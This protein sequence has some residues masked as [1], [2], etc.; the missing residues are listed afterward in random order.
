MK[1]INR[2]LFLLLLSANLWAQPNLWEGSQTF[3][4][5]SLWNGANHWV[6][7]YLGNANGEGPDTNG[8]TRLHAKLSDFY[9]E[10]SEEPIVTQDTNSIWTIRFTDPPEQADPTN[11]IRKPILLESVKARTNDLCVYTVDGKTVLRVD[12][13]NQVWIRGEPVGL[14]TTNGFD[15]TP[16]LPN[17]DTGL[18]Y[19]AIAAWR[20]QDVRDIRLIIPIGQRLWSAENRASAK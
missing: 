20:N 9:V 16:Q 14:I 15:P 7:A 11:A 6:T 5:L 8:E 13:R 1:T 2:S 10:S 3:S 19:G 4:E 17:F 12:Y 18:Q